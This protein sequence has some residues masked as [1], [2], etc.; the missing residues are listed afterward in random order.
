MIYDRKKHVFTGILAVEDMK[1]LCAYLIKC[2]RETW[3]RGFARKG[4]MDCVRRFIDLMP[5]KNT[6][7]RIAMVNSYL[8]N[9]YFNKA[10]KLFL[11]MP[12][13]NVPSRNIM[14]SSCLSGNRVNEAIHL[15]ESRCERGIMF[16]GPL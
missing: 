14:I 1:M 6:I 16:C 11:E 12:K 8:D 3:C 2:L 10:Y 15:F 4:L 13:R 5:D 7:A 9:G